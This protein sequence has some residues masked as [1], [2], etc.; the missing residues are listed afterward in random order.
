VVLVDPQGECLVQR[1]E[2]GHDRLPGEFGQAQGRGRR[3]ATT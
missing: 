3:Y 1:D 2:V